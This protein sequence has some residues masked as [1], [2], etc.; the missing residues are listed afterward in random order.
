MSSIPKQLINEVD[1]KNNDTNDFLVN[2][3]NKELLKCEAPSNGLLSGMIITWLSVVGILFW[4]IF[5]PSWMTPFFVNPSPEFLNAFLVSIIIMAIHKYESFYFEEYNHCPVYL[6]SGRKTW[7]KNSREAIF[8]PFVGTFLGLT[9]LLYFSLCGQ[10]WTMLIP[11]VWLAQ[12][13]HEIHHSAKALAQKKY[14]PGTVSS[15]VYVLQINLLLYPAWW[16]ALAASNQA[17]FYFYYLVQPFVFA[18]FYFE[19][20]QFTRLQNVYMKI[21]K[22]LEQQKQYN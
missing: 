3:S 15:I 20:R 11:I 4:G 8:L 5:F 2:M 21:Q 16:N 7:A 22:H 6:T 12:G 18:G 14:Y 19:H 17:V 13:L 1:T 10:P 9:F